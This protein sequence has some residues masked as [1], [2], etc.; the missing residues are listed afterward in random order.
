MGDGLGGGIEPAE[1]GGEERG[2][3]VH[4]PHIPLLELCAGLRVCRSKYV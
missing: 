3:G 4:P 2:G 1:H